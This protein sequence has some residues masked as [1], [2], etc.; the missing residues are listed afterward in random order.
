M[1]ARDRLLVVAAVAVLVLVWGTTWAVIRIGLEGIPPFTEDTGGDT[2]GGQR[3]AEII[4][5][6]VC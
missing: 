6:S 2:D 4:T 3:A 5:Y 1:Q